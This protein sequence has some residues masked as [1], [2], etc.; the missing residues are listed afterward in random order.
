MKN[1][2]TKNES[3]QIDS[4]TVSETITLDLGDYDTAIPA[5][6][7]TGIST[8]SLDDMIT[9]SV[10]LPN[11]YSI[12]NGGTGFSYSTSGNYTWAPSSS[13]VHIDADGLTMKEGA[14]IKVGGKSL[15]EAIEKIE[16]RL[17]IL[18]PNT[19]LEDRWEQLKDLRRQYMEL[20][21]DLLEKEKIMKILKET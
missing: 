8:I 14:D 17:G 1:K 16:E 15:M 7:S 12:S 13:T 10:T 5:L 18:K 11:N 20:E 9:T 21:K 4:L 6:T 2:K 19:D 3:S